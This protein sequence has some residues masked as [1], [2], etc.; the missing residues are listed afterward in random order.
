MNV[1]CNSH[2]IT[3]FEPLTTDA[4]SSPILIQNVSKSFRKLQILQISFDIISGIAYYS[5]FV[6]SIKTKAL[7]KERKKDSYSLKHNSGIPV[8]T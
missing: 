2:W 6:S 8:G 3:L 7:V 5:T 1:K 4:H